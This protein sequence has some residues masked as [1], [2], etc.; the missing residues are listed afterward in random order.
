M[1]FQYCL[2]RLRN[3]VEIIPSDQNPEYTCDQVAN[4]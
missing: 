3:A 4:H 1:T 2:S